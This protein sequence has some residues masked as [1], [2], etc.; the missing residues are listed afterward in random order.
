MRATVIS[1]M[2]Y[3]FEIRNDVAHGHLCLYHL[4]NLIQNAQT[5]EKL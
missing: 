4:Y 2:N 5:I 3:A 1:V